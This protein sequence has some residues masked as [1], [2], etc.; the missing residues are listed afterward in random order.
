LNAL[1]CKKAT[2]FIKEYVAEINR[3]GKARKLNAAQFHNRCTQVEAMCALYN[4]L[5]TPH[6]A[7]VNYLDDITIELRYKDC[8]VKV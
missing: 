6:K 1:E 7:Y 5:D 2:Q 4:Q 3:L 8:N